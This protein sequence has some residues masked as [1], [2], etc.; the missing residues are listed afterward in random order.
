MSLTLLAKAESVRSLS[1][2]HSDAPRG[3]AGPSK[4][5]LVR[6]LLFI[7]MVVAV[8]LVGRAWAR[9]KAPGNPVTSMAAPIDGVPSASAPLGT[10]REPA[11][12]AVSRNDADKNAD[13][14]ADRNHGKNP[15]KS[16]EDSH[17]RVVNINLATAADLES[18]PYVGP[19][20]AEAIL[21]LRT[22]LGQF[23]NVEQLLKVKGIGRSTLRRI[24]P[25]ITLAAPT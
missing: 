6:G 17:N 19:K 2:R 11:P 10:T 20:R 8:S 12:E 1:G 15:A 7:A 13:K 25:R 5:A 18:L 23:K 3:S 22:K 24:R 21:S 4:R 16:S 9:T 14:N